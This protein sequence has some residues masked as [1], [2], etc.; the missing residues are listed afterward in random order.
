MPTSR[1]RPCLS[2]NLKPT[3]AD[4]RSK[5]FARNCDP[6]LAAAWCALA[7]RC[8]D[9]QGDYRFWLSVFK[10]FLDKTC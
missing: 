2:K 9:R 7:A 10:N 3:G 5:I 4:R 1:N 6:A 8:D